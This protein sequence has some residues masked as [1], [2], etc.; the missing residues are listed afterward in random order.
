MNKETLFKIIQNP[1]STLDEGEPAW[2]HDLISAYPY[3]QTAYVLLGMV[4]HA[5][6]TP[7]FDQWLERIAISV[8]S[9]QRFY[10]LLGNQNREE[11]GEL[12]ELDQL[13]RQTH[14]GYAI[15]KVDYNNQKNTA[16]GDDEA[17]ETK[18][19]GQAIVDDFLAKYNAV[20]LN[21]KQASGENTSSPDQKQHQTADSKEPKPVTVISESAAAEAEEAGEL[22]KA[23]EIYEKL[24]LQ[25]PNRFNYFVER[26]EAL[27]FQ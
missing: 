9:R 10:E 25:Y 17:A 27:K 16:K 8:N 12:Q 15:S 20:G 3:F 4:Y 23:I 19:A 11:S 2:F 22:K 21:A 24:S 14:P 26:A 5:E 7:W 13:I 6:K 1:D 18:S